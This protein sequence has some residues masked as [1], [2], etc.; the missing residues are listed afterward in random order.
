MPRRNAGRQVSLCTVVEGP[1]LT[2]CQILIAKS[3]K[4]PPFTDTELREMAINFPEGIHFLLLVKL[5][6]DNDSSDEN[7]MLEIPGIEPERVRLHGKKFLKLIREAHRSYEEMMQQ[8]EDHPQDPNHQNVINISSDEEFGGDGEFDDFEVDEE[9][10][11]ETS[12]YFDTDVAAFNRQCKQPF[13]HR[14]STN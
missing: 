12:L 10:Q 5:A 9:S 11:G 7:E 14:R 3:L 4:R 6:D 8:Q 2:D 13:R 1:L